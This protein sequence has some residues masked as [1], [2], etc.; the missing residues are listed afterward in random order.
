MRNRIIAVAAAV[1]IIAAV[2]IIIATATSVKNVKDLKIETSGTAQTLNW[3]VPNDKYS[4]EIYRLI[5]GT[6][7]EYELAGEAEQGA[8]SFT[9][10]TGSELT[11]NTYKV[12]SVKGKGK[13]GGKKISAYTAPVQPQNVTA[14]TVSSDSVDLTWSG[15][16]A[17]GGF[18]VYYSENAD[19]QGA[20]QTD[21]EASQAQK[22]GAY[23]YTV[24]GLS[25]NTDYYFR[26]SAY[27]DINEKGYEG[28]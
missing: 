11:L 14:K 27:A 20:A 8:S 4:Y 17:A 5:P 3:T 12:V 7:D 26:V 10:D 15:S 28:R 24:S 21:V 16:Q 13:S 9:V 19:M 6:K 25:S 18:T 1:I 22:D 2:V 23:G